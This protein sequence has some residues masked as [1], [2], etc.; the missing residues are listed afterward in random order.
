MVSRLSAA[1]LPALHDLTT[2]SDGD[3]SIALL[4]AWAAVSDVLCFYQERLANEVFLRTATERRSLVE[5]AALV[6]YIP[7]PGVAASAYLAFTLDDTAVPG[8]VPVPVG[9]R[10]QSIPGPGEKPQVFET[11]EAIAGRSEWN[12]MKPLM[13]QK[14]PAIT[15]TSERVTLR[16]IA[17][18]L[19]KGDSMLLLCG[20]GDSNRV[21][22]RVLA[23][24]ADPVSQTTRVDLVEDPP[25]PPPFHLFHLQA[26]IWNPAPLKLT[27]TSVASSVLAGSW[28]QADLKAYASVQKWSL[29]KLNIHIGTIF[30][31]ILK[32][33]PPEIGVFALRARASIFGH[34]APKYTTLPATQ[35]MTDYV[36]GATGSLVPKAPP[37]PT[38]WEG[39][40]LSAEPGASDLSIDLDQTHPEIVKGSWLVMED[41]HRRDIYKVSDNTE[42]SR[43]DFTL[44][45]KVSR[46]KLSSNTNFNNYR[47]RDTNVLAQSEKLEL[48]ELP[49][50]DTIKGNKIVLDRPHLGLQVGRAVA[51]TGL[52]VDLE[53]VT[54]SEI[55]ILSE[56]ILDQG[57]TELT[58]V[59]DLANEYQ[60]A[61][62]TV[63]AN[64]A[65]A[66]HG[67]TK[68]QALGSGDSSRPF[69]KFVVLE[70]PLTYVSADNPQGAAS[71]LQ[72]R[73]NQLLWQEVPSFYAH[74]PEER[75]YITRT[76]EEGKTIVEFGDGHTGARLPTGNENVRVI[77]RKGMGAEGLVAE[78]QLSLLLTKPLGLRGVINPIAAGEAADAESRDDVRRNASLPIRTLDRI[79]SLRDYE[80]FARA[81]SGVAKAL[82]TWTW[83]GRERG[84]FVTVAGSAGQAIEPGGLIYQNL[85]AAI[86]QAGDPGVPLRVKTYR[87]A[88]FRV[89]GK[90]SIRADYLAD[91]VKGAVE[92]ALRESFSFDSRE[93]GQA[94]AKS[95]VIAVIQ[96]VKGVLAVDL[97]ELYRT[98]ALEEE[99]AVTK[100]FDR[101]VAQVPVSGAPGA[102][103]FPSDTA[104]DVALGAEL[105]LLDPR[106]IHFGIMKGQNT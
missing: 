19:R 41:Q 39:R 57:Y 12:A 2:R 9:T 48:A 14:H 13:V 87:S 20:A 28:K 91:V 85:V 27:T 100:L 23:V 42:L 84:V 83:N 96:R 7:R 29:P 17:T 95:E 8:D 30:K 93:F 97:D 80:D 106:P 73:V 24:A 60:R 58:F 37:Y 56:V 53:G 11:V 69:Q 92:A 33:F 52:R 101:L 66:T 16:G 76:S 77:Y 79:V 86:L 88:F 70:A 98:D 94:V 75:V 32:F 40:K 99:L 46:I 50:T 90:L 104:G 4:D 6:G 67:E 62:V 43:T 51:V 72:V 59:N 65:L 64:V 3:F 44:T 25:D 68:D 5:L 22:K 89:S 81:F 55:M 21:V 54:D 82:G 74:G 36:T 34:N 18:N 38:D 105:L 103:S 63:N 35:R 45:G 47:I 15:P 71:T 1:D 61:S 102:G 49:I 31:L 26:A 10:V 78:G